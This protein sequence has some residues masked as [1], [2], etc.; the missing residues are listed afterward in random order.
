[1]DHRLIDYQRCRWNVEEKG[2]AAD[3]RPGRPHH[4]QVAHSCDASLYRGSRSGMAYWHR[5]SVA[6]LRRGMACL[7]L[8]VR[9]QAA[10]AI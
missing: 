3:R 6:S 1:M 8:V 2:F 7:R 9:A 10:A 5:D 4:V